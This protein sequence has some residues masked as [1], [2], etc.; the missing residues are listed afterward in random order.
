MEATSDAEHQLTATKNT[1]DYYEQDL[2]DQFYKSVWGGHYINI[3]IY[4]SADEDIVT[5][6]QRTVERMATFAESI[7]SETRILDLGSGYGGSARYLAKTYSCHVTCLNLSPAQNTR[8][9]DLC[10]AEGLEQLVTIIEGNFEEVPLPDHTFDLVW[11][12]DAFLHSG[13][14]KGLV[15]EIDRLLV[16]EGGRVVFTDILQGDDIPDPT[17]LEAYLQRLPVEDLGT[18][19]FYQSLFK[20]RQFSA[21]TFQDLTEHLATHYTKVRDGLEQYEQ[22][23]MKQAE[24]TEATEAFFKRSKAG[25]ASAVSLATKKI[26]RWGIFVFQR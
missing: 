20:H 4:E 2:V 8:N 22:D 25:L 16:T 1:Y 15:E 11:S 5:A 13:N 24:N 12:Q 6:S 10:K 3:G 14:R 21:D 18:V 17:A 23:S 7:S 9:R 19:G 26:L